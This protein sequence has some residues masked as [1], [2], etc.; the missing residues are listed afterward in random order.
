[1]VYNLWPVSLCPNVCNYYVNSQ[2]FR[3]NISDMKSAFWIPLQGI[4]ELFHGLKRFPRHNIINVL[5]CLCKVPI[6]PVQFQRSLNSF[7]RFW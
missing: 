1:M 5:K 2:I 4:S 3:E 7:E 6:I